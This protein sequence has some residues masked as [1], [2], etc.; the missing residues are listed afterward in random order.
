MV[1]KMNDTLMNQYVTKRDV[2]NAICF[3]CLHGDLDEDRCFNYPCA[4]IE[5]VMRMPVKQPEVIR[6]RECKHVQHDEMFYQYWCNGNRVNPDHFCGYAE[7][8]EDE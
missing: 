8:R 1:M 6:C 3:D 4:E 7:R 5:A 2:I